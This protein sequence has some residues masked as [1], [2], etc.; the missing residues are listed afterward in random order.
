[1]T[2]AFALLSEPRRPW[3]DPDALKCRVV[4]LLAAS[5]PDRV[6]A[7]GEAGRRAANERHASLNAAYNTLRE[8][9]DRLLHLYELEAGERPKDIQRIPPGTMDLFVDV[10]QTCRDLDAFL[11]RKAGATSPMVRVTLMQEGFEW[12][13]RLQALQS[14]VNARHDALESEL[15]SLNATWDA[16]PALDSPERRAALPMERLEQLYRSMSYVARWSA[17]LQERM[18]GL[19]E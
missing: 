9:R 8:P 13:D 6:H 4:P 17:Q 7:D 14:R 15:K 3:L 11:Q 10:G 12:L 2:D 1:M 5:H 16:A 19:A 18:V